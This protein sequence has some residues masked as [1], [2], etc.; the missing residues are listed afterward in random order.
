MLT[1]LL[2]IGELQEFTDTKIRELLYNMDMLSNVAESLFHTMN[3]PVAAVL[4]IRSSQQN[5]GYECHL[6]VSYTHL[7]LPTILRV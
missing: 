5:R 7:T 6:P 2:E 3:K 4:V 1:I